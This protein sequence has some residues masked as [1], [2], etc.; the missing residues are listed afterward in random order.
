[1]RLASLLQTKRKPTKDMQTDWTAFAEGVCVA[2]IWESRPGRFTAQVNTGGKR[3]SKTFDS[4]RDAQRWARHFEV[5]VDEGKRPDR[6]ATFTTLA[7]EYLTEMIA[8]KEPS[9]SKLAAIRIICEI[10]GHRKVSELDVAAFRDFARQRGGSGAGPATILMDLSYVGS[11]LRHGGALADVPTDAALAALS[12][13]RA[14]MSASG[15]VARPEERKRRPTDAELLALRD[16]W[17]R[18]RRGIPMW[19]L[20][21]FA[22]ASA[23][24][25]SEILALRWA[26]LDE[27]KRL[28][29]IRDRKHPRSKKGNDQ[30]VPLLCGPAVIGGEV[31]DPLAL[32]KAQPKESTLIFPYGAATVSTSFT[33]AVA[34]CGIDDLHMHDLR[35]D[36]V[37]RLFEARYAIEQVSIV[38]GHRDWNMLRRYTQI[39]PEA[40]HRD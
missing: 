32:I 34:G 26:D 10:I 21:R 27:D 29:L 13:A 31:I 38:S 20:T 22:V 15:T 24:R 23:M 11:I 1:M 4:K 16:H 25:L 9:R 14:V 37:S 6:D 5:A 28:I 30:L 18:R 12:T 17:A 8:A 36:G 35:H 39:N 33:R 19:T 2:S 3:L 40:L 7:E